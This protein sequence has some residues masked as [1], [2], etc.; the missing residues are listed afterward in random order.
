MGTPELA[1]TLLS[2]LAR[3][4][5]LEIV[6][7]V[8]QPD[9]PAGRGLA[10]QMPPVKEEALSRNLPVLQPGKARDRDFVAT[11]RGLAP[12]V[13]VVAAYGQ[14]LPPEL[15]EIPRSACLNVHL[16][17][18]PRWRGAAPIAWAILA[19][20]AET[21]VTLMRMDPGLDTGDVVAQEAT[22]ILDTDTAQTLQERL[23]ALGA[24]LLLRTLPA[25]LAG[26]LTPRPQPSS[27]ITHAP[28]LTR[29]DGRLHWREPAVGLWRR[30]RGLNP[31]PGAFTTFAEANGAPVLLK[32][33][34]ASPVPDQ[35]SPGVVLR[36]DA[37]SLVVGT[38]QDALRL[39]VVQREGR[40]RLEAREF[41]K[42]QMVH[43]GDLLGAE[44]VPGDQ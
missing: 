41:L 9:R 22:P 21:G 37:E 25:W 13:I 34:E 3:D 31:W 2:A 40:R 23:G 5:S 24:S 4:P 17:L 19:G 29:E 39:L 15:L 32:I 42:G 35:G 28:K 26:E 8:A 30:I 27:G 36:A 14:L 6:L 44:P 18:L 11:I 43:P 38:G 33:W 20:D 1:R 12:D 16:S 10:L 7:V